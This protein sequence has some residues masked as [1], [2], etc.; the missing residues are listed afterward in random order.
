MIKI[1]SFYVDN[2]VDTEAKGMFMVFEMSRRQCNAFI[3]AC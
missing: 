1:C 2:I 3:T